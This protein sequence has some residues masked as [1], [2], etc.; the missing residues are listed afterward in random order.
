MHPRRRERQ[1]FQQLSAL[2]CGQRAFQVS[3]AVRRNMLLAQMPKRCISNPLN[4]PAAAMLRGVA[5]RNWISCRPIFTVREGPSVKKG[6]LAGTCSDGPRR[7]V[8]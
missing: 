7:F 5:R 1:V 6:A 4:R 3:H 8:A 2:F